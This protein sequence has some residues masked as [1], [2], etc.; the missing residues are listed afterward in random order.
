MKQENGKEGRQ[1]SIS[2]R[3]WVLGLLFGAD[4]MNHEFYHHYYKGN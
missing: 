1:P 2:K 3:M 4:F